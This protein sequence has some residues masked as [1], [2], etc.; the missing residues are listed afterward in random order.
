MRR[1]QSRLKSAVRERLVTMQD[2]Y[3]GATRWDGSFVL[4]LGLFF[5]GGEKLWRHGKGGPNSLTLETIGVLTQV[6]KAA[7]AGYLSQTHER[8]QPDSTTG[9]KGQSIRRGFIRRPGGSGLG[10][11]CCWKVPSVLSASGG[12]GLP[13][14]LWWIT[15][16]PTKA[17]WNSSGM[18]KTCKLFANHVMTARPP[19]KAAREK[20]VG[21][22]AIKLM[23]FD[24]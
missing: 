7:F 14:Q 2:R 13:R 24:Y 8:I 17:T 18:K 3:A 22:S 9:K 12:V 16:S 20:R 21:C 6:D 10:S 23:A 5:I 1:F 4:V 15:S 11:G 19:R